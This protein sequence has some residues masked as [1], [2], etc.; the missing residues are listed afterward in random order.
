MP[1][2]TFV[3]ELYT[4]RLSPHA[5]EYLQMWTHVDEHRIAT[6][7]RQRLYRN[8]L[9]A[10]I[11]TGP[12]PP[13]LER[14][15][16]L[17]DEPAAEAGEQQV[18]AVDEPA[19]VR[20]RRLQVAS[21]KPAKIQT[22]PLAETLHVLLADEK[23]VRGGTYSQAQPA[24]DVRG[25]AE[26]NGAVRL[27]L[28]PEIEH[29]E[30]QRQWDA[31]DGM[32][33]LKPGRPKKAFD[34]LRIGVDLLPGQLLVV[35]CIAGREGSLGDKLLATNAAEADQHTLLAIRLAQ[36]PEAALF[37]EASEGDET[38]DVAVAGQ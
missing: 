18:V 24:W 20:M 9:R 22:A 16:Q 25:Y 35:G 27:N 26:A 38:A 12:L 17:S 13:E 32:M 30:V 37:A 14:L 10:G 15:L 1:A 23:G 7:L 5:G 34:Q 33:F 29:G 11:V 8:G 31:S 28:A 36:A 21:G 4:V 6:P 3:L 2:D 19:Q